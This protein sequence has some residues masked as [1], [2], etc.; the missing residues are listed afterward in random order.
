MDDFGVIVTCSTKDYLFAK[1]CCASIRYFM[2]RTPLCLLIDGDFPLQ[3]LDK[4]YHPHIINRHTVRTPFLRQRSFG[5]GITKMIAFWESPFRHFLLLDADTC[6]WGDMSGH[7]DFAR[8]DVIVDIPEYRYSEESINEFFF[9]TTA[10]RTHFPRFDY[11][12]Y[13]DS[14]FCTGVLFGTRDTFD[15]REYRDV[16]NFAVEHPQVFKYGEMGFL[17]FMLFR[18]SEE[19][20]VRLGRAD[21]QYIVRDYPCDTTKGLFEV[22][23][24]PVVKRPATAL[25]YCAAKPTRNNTAHHVEPML[26]FRRCF[27]RELLKTTDE[28]D[29]DARID[30]EDRLFFLSYRKPLRDRIGS[31]AKAMI[32]G[33]F[34]TVYD[35]I[36][37][38]RL[39]RAK[40]LE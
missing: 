32:R 25:H 13:D 19:G 39:R 1:G 36:K 20:R 33:A 9:D 4:V 11:L 21:I 16:L 31:R 3:G 14:Y 22:K 40:P 17:N 6:A 34:P 7:A 5:W 29:I 37:R 28:A 35:A 24:A 18:A 8:Y 23:D 27:L 2:P 38:S 30:H 26:Y 12:K 15:I 10:M